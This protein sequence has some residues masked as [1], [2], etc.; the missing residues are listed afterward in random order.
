[1]VHKKYTYKNGKRF[2]PYYY[3]TKRVNGKVVTIYLGSEMPQEKN[4]A[5]SPTQFSWKK[6]IPFFIITAILLLLFLPIDFTGKVTLDIK[7]NYNFGE[8]VD[9]TL[10]LN[11]KEGELVPANSKLLVSLGN[12]K[13]EFVLSDLIDDELVEG[14][15]YAE[16][17]SISGT[18]EGYGSPGSRKFY[19]D[20]SFDLKI[21]KQSDEGTGEVAGG[22]EG[23][24]AGSGGETAGEGAVGFEQPAEENPEDNSGSNSNSESNSNGNSGNGDKD[25]SDKSSSDENSKKD[26]GNGNGGENLGESSGDSESITGSVV[27]ENEDIVSGKAS[28]DN[29]FEYVLAEGED[30]EIVSGSVRVNG[31]EIDEN[32]LKV[33]IQNG[34][35]VVSTDYSYEEEGFGEEF[36]GGRKMKLEIDI[37]SFRFIAENDSLFSAEL[38]YQ[39]A[40]LTKAE[41][42]ISVAE[43]ENETEVTPP[44]NVTNG[45]VVIPPINITELNQTILNQTIINDSLVAVNLTQSLAVLGQPVKWVKTVGFNSS[46]PEI[47]VV[48]IPLSAD[49]IT[50]VKIKRES[51]EISVDGVINGTSGDMTDEIVIGINESEVIIDSS[52]G[53]ILFNESSSGGQENGNSGAIEPVNES[54]EIVQEVVT[55]GVTGQVIHGRVT[56][57]IE[58]EN[59]G[60]VSWI[61]K[62]FRFSGFVI[63]N[64]TAPA[65]GAVQ[66]VQI[67]LNES[68][69]GVQ[70]EYWTDAPYAVETEKMNGKEVQVV[71]PDDVHYENVTIFT[72]INESLGIRVASKLKIYWIE[73]GTSLTAT[74]VN[75]TDGNGVYDYIEWI[76]PSLSNQTFEIILITKAEHL[77]SNR[78]FVSDIYE[79]VRELDGNWSEAIPAGDYVRVTFEVNLTNVNDITAYPRAANWTNISDVVIDVYENNKSEVIA[80]FT[81]LADNTE[82]KVYLTGLQNS[83][84]TFDLHVLNGSLEFD[85]ITD[86]S[87]IVKVYNFS[88]LADGKRAYCYDRG[89]DTPNNPSTFT[90]YVEWNDTTGFG[91]CYN[92][93]SN[94]ENNDANRDSDDSVSTSGSKYVN[95][96]YNFS[97]ITED[98]STISSIQV[99]WIGY[100]QLNEADDFEFDIWNF[101]SGAWVVINTTTTAQSSDQTYGWT[102]T[103]TNSNLSSFLQG[104]DLYLGVSGD[105]MT[106]GPPPSPFIYSF[107]SKDYKFEGDILEGLDSKEKEGVDVRRLHYLDWQ[108]PSVKVTNELKEIEYIDYLTLNVTYLDFADNSEFSVLYMPYNLD[109]KTFD[110]INKIDENYL[111]LEE[112]DEFILKFANLGIKG[113]KIIAKDLIVS[114]YYEK[115][116]GWKPVIKK[117]HT[118][119]TNYVE[120]KVTTSTTPDPPFFRM[121]GPTNNSVVHGYITPVIN[122]TIFQPDAGENTSVIIYGENT[123]P[124]STEYMLYY[125]ASGA[126]NNT[127]I[128]YD[129]T[130]QSLHR[131]E[132]MFLLYHFDNNSLYGEND[133]MFVDFSYQG[134]NGTLTA[135][136][137]SFPAPGKIGQAFQVDANEYINLTDGG[138]PLLNSPSTTGNISILFWINLTNDN[139]T[140]G[141]FISI[142]GKQVSTN[143][144]DYYIYYRNTTGRIYTSFGNGSKQ[145]GI[146]SSTRLNLS[147]WY[148]V[149][150]TYNKDTMNET[151]YIDGLADNSGI[152]A[153]VGG[154]IDTTADLWVFRANGHP[155]RP[156]FLIDD[157]AIY[158]RSLNWTE[159][160][161]IY[162][163]RNETYYWRVNATDT[164]SGKNLSE[165]FAFTRGEL[166]LSC[167]DLNKQGIVY[168]QD[169]NFSSMQGSFNRYCINVSAVNVT[170]NCGGYRMINN[171]LAA[172]PG[173]LIFSNQLNTTIRDCSNLTSNLDAIYFAGA[174]KSTIDNITVSGGRIDFSAWAST[175]ANLRMVTSAAYA[176]KIAQAGNDSNKIYNLTIIGPASNALNLSVVRDNVFDNVTIRSAVNAIALGTSANNTFN[177]FILY[178]ILDKG[179]YITSGGNHS[180]VNLTINQSNYS[181]WMASIDGTGSYDSNNF[182]NVFIN[183]SKRDAI[184]IGTGASATANNN[185]FVNVT[186]LNTNVSRFDLLINHTSANETRFEDFYI[187]NYSFVTTGGS[188]IF[189]NSSLG[190]IKFLVAS[191]NG[192]GTNLT[193]DVRIGNNSVT[194]VTGNNNVLNKTAIVTLYGMKTN[195]SNPQI[196]RDNAQCPVGVCANTT[197]LNAGTVVFNVTGW[198]N[199]SIQDTNSVSGCANLSA[200]GVTYTQISNIVPISQTVP[201]INITAPNV[202]FNGANFWIRNLTLTQAIIYSDQYNT[203]IKNVNVSTK[204]AITVNTAATGVRFGGADYSTIK[205]SI[206]GAGLVGINLTSTNN[207]IFTNL[208][209]MNQRMGVWNDRGYHNYFGNVSISNSTASGFYITLGVNTT[210]DSAFVNGSTAG[211]GIVTFNA[212]ESILYNVTTHNSQTG[213]LFQNSHNNV[214]RNASIFISTSAGLYF[215]QGVNNI[216]S[217]VLINRSVNN[218]RVELTN[219][220][221]FS[222]ITSVNGTIGLYFGTTSYNNTFVN[223]SFNYNSG[224]GVYTGS[225]SNNTYRNI[226]A[227]DNLGSDVYVDASNETHCNNAFINFN[228]SRGLPFGYYNSSVTLTDN[229]FS[230]L[231]LCNADYSVLTRVNVSG[232]SSK[233]NNFAFM[234]YSDNVN[235]SGLNSSFN[236]YG[237]WLD[238]LTGLRLTNLFASN[239]TDGVYVNLVTYSNLDGIIV[240][241][242]TKGIGLNGVSFGNNFTNISARD[243]TDALYYSTI[244]L[245]NAISNLTAHNNIHGVYV[246][247]GSN[248]TLTNATINGSYQDAITIWQDGEGVLGDTFSFRFVNVS[249]TNTGVSYYDLN[250][251]SGDSS[252]Q[253]NVYIGNVTFVNT[254]L[255]TYIINGQGGAEFT[256]GITGLTVEDTRFGIISLLD[257]IRFTDTNIVGSNFSNDIFLRNQTATVNHNSHIEFNVSANVTLY[258]VP[259][260][261]TTANLLRDTSPC[262]AAVC[263]NYTALTAGTV[264]FGVTGWTNYSVNGSVVAPNSAPYNLSALYFNSSVG[265]N[266]TL[267]NFTVTARLIDPDG[268]SMNLT[269]YWFN[270]SVTYSAKNYNSN[271]ANNTVVHFDLNHLNTTKGENWSAG[272]FIFDG[273]VNSTMAN[274]SRITINNSAPNITFT[275]PFNGNVTIDRSPSFFYNITDYDGDATW[276]NLNVSLV[277]T[278]ACTDS[279]YNGHSK[280]FIVLL[281]SQTVLTK[282]SPDLTCLIDHGDWYNWSAQAND[283]E[284][285]WGGWTKLRNLS[286]QAYLSISLPN[287]SVNFSSIGYQDWND[288]SDN[289]PWPLSVQNDGNAFVNVSLSASNLWNTAINPTAYY[290]FKA[291]NVSGENGSFRWSLSPSTY[292]NVTA[293]GEP[294]ICLA[295]LNWTDTRDWAEIDLNVTVPNNEGSGP[296]NSIITFIASLAE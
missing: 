143:D 15:F 129:W 10:R 203:T 207:S 89:G 16:G 110:K 34:Q 88:S 266:Q 37:G 240:N 132:G 213:I 161:D 216:A 176:F 197:S 261:Y 224:Y 9:G 182:T 77:D 73:N 32:E 69:S 271:Y 109:K 172:T 222:N 28:K 29:D 170:F 151:I 47:L 123:T 58:L 295:E 103:S 13:K 92:S 282:L 276:A 114:G 113:T 223:S 102:F 187:G 152:L 12:L 220:S 211:Q 145:S 94:L 239:N 168:T 195:Y 284:G 125:N 206:F 1:M 234:R 71:S 200:Q 231:I 283:S 140:A 112:G 146:E 96:W 108:R 257:D 248:L 278:S 14:G 218:L 238:Y 255:L 263:T 219:N 115:L 128:T 244:S 228:V 6:F 4:K 126:I 259:T 120:V 81:N 166:V 265:N 25:K 61:R 290:Q 185:S 189:K 35:A 267:E 93:Y 186:V 124:P 18:G 55:V 49:N 24:P 268:N 95:H 135:I 173:A 43:P 67:E 179:V 59:K 191:V 286:L 202:T 252:M 144:R 82:N 192:S 178:D 245:G 50:Y 31:K 57:D 91:K 249:V 217:D 5:S 130:S 19:P 280:D 75:D 107:D 148:H 269:L 51:I 48:E 289:S 294:V 52:N 21:S 169:F 212:N 184:L 155:I 196:Y 229:E 177:N 225:V 158:N 90:A 118:L 208:T 242:N 60:F 293:D 292:T 174:N 131:S 258:N 256:N 86:P 117:H 8:E 41:K 23:E 105:K 65:E 87:G 79:S 157:L 2:G 150:I 241:N 162:R 183:N 277:A 236:Y 285:Y 98:V 209:I 97:A 262:P 101:T 272:I 181:I 227:T 159:V 247:G 39:G 30:A 221:I 133:T 66:E 139:Y 163:L 270:Q 243:N 64:E 68:D 279:V 141:D 36:L 175:A 53:T 121:N 138:H 56:A 156:N 84:N 80:Q 142:I 33:K 127:E 288:T 232:S 287:S 27:S 198:S 134:Q 274:T 193:N 171:T 85:Y 99:T 253:P 205:N 254:P 260:T 44:I 104:G 204:Y 147:R 122:V 250:L 180:F 72:N 194:V 160:R 237:L 149:A 246:Y 70:V 26:N 188:H 45:T 164:S 136:N 62:I 116:P 3:E 214:V 20:V 226:N 17:V 119:F 11:L 275:D 167:Q 78:E 83:Q 76:A 7:S 281:G 201:C 22:S 154:L 230:E 210:I 100:D 233:Q 291:D 273:T 106:Y 38:V 42:D 111:I 63:S 199:Y 54:A 40:V 251:I 296:R 235:V 46:V 153:L 74:V 190:M 264:T 137:G 215:I 165:T